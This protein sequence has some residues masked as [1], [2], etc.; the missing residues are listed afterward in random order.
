MPRAFLIPITPKLIGPLQARGTHFG[1]FDSVYSLGANTHSLHR[2]PARQANGDLSPNQSSGWGPKTARPWRDS[3][4]STVE[5]VNPGSLTSH[6]GAECWESGHAAG[7]QQASRSISAIRSGRTGQANGMTSNHHGVESRDTNEPETQHGNVGRIHAWNRR[8]PDHPPGNAHLNRPAESSYASSVPLLDQLSDNL[9]PRGSYSSRLGDRSGDQFY[10]VSNG[11]HLGLVQGESNLRSVGTT[12]PLHQTTPRLRTTPGPIHASEM[13]PWQTAPG[14]RSSDH[15]PHSYNGLSDPFG[16]LPPPNGAHPSSPAELESAFGGL[17]LSEVGKMSVS[18]VRSPHDRPSPHMARASPIESSIHSDRGSSRSRQSPNDWYWNRKSIPHFES[19]DHPVVGAGNANLNT[20]AY[21]NTA[22]GIG[23]HSRGLRA[24][25]HAFHGVSYQEQEYISRMV[26]DFDRRPFS[27]SALTAPDP[28]LD[29][30]REEQ[31]RQFCSYGVMQRSQ[32]N[33]TSSLP[34]HLFPYG[35][36]QG[37]QN[38]AQFAPLPHM[39]EVMPV[40]RGL[41]DLP[42]GH[43]MRSTLLDEF[44]TLTSNK[45][46]RHFELRVR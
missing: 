39:P 10:R 46:S 5:Q 41:P 25:D 43:G 32:S 3:G 27:S 29:R 38:R 15:Q 33:G 1:G 20:N 35:L 26:P 44:K 9:E 36:A 12:P 18:C 40:S 6:R 4:F 34:S 31:W 19:L 17:T 2:S 45:G 24:P 7:N 8:D 28:K 30:T 23:E 42:P 16:G 13:L 37:M 21:P 11:D 22:I 14:A